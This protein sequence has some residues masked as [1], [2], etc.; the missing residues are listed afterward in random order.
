MK[1]LIFNNSIYSDGFYIQDI[2]ENEFDTHSDWFFV[3]CGDDITK[4]RHYYIQTTNTFA[5]R[6]EVLDAEAEA[7]AEPNAEEEAQERAIAEPNAEEE[8]TE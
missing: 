6:Q 2:V 8:A 4:E 7:E 3:D 1:A 5:V